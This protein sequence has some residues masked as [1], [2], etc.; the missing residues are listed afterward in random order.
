MKPNSCNCF[1]ARCTVPFDNPKSRAA[2]SIERD[3]LPLL[4]PLNLALISHK[5]FKEGPPNLRKASLW[6]VEYGR[7]QY[8]TSSLRPDLLALL[9]R[10]RP[11]VF[12]PTSQATEKCFA[13]YIHLP[14]GPSQISHRPHVFQT[15]DSWAQ[16]LPRANVRAFEPINAEVLLLRFG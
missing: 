6:T 11:T 15:C 4:N 2:S 8:W 9:L 1:K 3:I 16:C 12:I 5:T 14:N 7:F 10:L 13:W